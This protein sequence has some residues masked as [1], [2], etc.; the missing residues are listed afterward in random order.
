M[1]QASNSCYM[2][3]VKLSIA[4]PILQHDRQVGKDFQM[5]L[6]ADKILSLGSGVL[7][8]LMGITTKL[9]PIHTNLLI[10]STSDPEKSNYFSLIDKYSLPMKLP[11]Q[12]Q[13]L[14]NIKTQRPQFYTGVI[15]EVTLHSVF[16]SVS[17]QTTLQTSHIIVSGHNYC[18]ETF[19]FNKTAAMNYTSVNKHLLK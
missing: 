18:L 10:L 6:T 1:L 16:S 13:G 14:H 9:F 15:C 2:Q 12:E 7:F 4:Q 19:L 8:F 5:I 3:W 11:F 17:L